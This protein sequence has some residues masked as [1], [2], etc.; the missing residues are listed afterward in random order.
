MRRLFTATIAVISVLFAPAIDSSA[1]S[2]QGDGPKVTGFSAEVTPTASQGPSSV[3]A[4]TI[5]VSSSDGI[6]LVDMGCNSDQTGRRDLL[7]RLFPKNIGGSNAIVEF[8]GTTRLDRPSATYQVAGE[9]HSW[10]I[11]FDWL[12]ELLPTPNSSCSFQLFAQDLRSR[13]VELETATVLAIGPDGGFSVREKAPTPAPTPTPTPSNTAKPAP[14]P[15]KYKNCAA[16]QKAYAGGV[17]LSS[18]SVNKGGKIKLKP[19]VNAKVYNLNKSLDRDKD[20]L[21]CER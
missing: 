3:L 13:W 4:L 11:R 21:A 6:Y 10:A 7:V 15:I 2:V 9:L 16:L 20:G 1:A 14:K 5:S 19:T 8:F 17:A 18:K 12:R